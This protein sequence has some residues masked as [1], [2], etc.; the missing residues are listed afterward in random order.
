MFRWTALVTLLIVMIGVTMASSSYQQGSPEN[1]FQAFLRDLRNDIEILADRAFPG[2][3]RPDGWSGETDFTADGM[4][5]SLFI[6]NELLADQIF[7]GERPVG[8]I[9]VS[10]T[11]A[12]IVARNIRHD[13]ELSADAWLGENLRPDEWIGGPLL[14]QCSELLMNTAYILDIE[15]NIRPR[16]PET[17]NDYCQSVTEEVADT[18]IPA[19]L[20][21]PQL[22]NVPDLLLAVRGDLE[23]LADEV[24][25]LNVRPGG[26]VDNTNVD[27]LA[28]IAD[29]IADMELLANITLDNRR[30]AAWVQPRSN[31]D[32]STFRNLRFNLELLAD[33]TLG[34]EVR[35]NGWQNEAQLFRCAPVIQSLVVLIST[36]YPY[37]LTT[38]RSNRS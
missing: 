32:V 1:L 30:P 31:D 21:A 9:G 5:A 7:A 24:L 3:Q 22:Q 11:V 12:D 26:W 10:S 34:T 35:P 4:L 37:E 27:D 6:D 20:G 8:W 2:A 14:F 19:A 29:L 17:V 28:Y 38:N 18:L 33:R 36:T 15:Y 16:T 25:G 13:L 23:R